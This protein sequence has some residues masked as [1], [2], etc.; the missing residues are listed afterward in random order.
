MDEIFHARLYR[1]R[2][3]PIQFPV[4]WLPG[5]SR[6]ETVRVGANYPP[7]FQ[8]RDSEGLDR[9]LLSSSVLAQAFYGGNPYFKKPGWRSLYSESVRDRRSGDRIPVGGEIFCTYPDRLRGTPS[10]L[11][12]GYRVF[13]GC[14]SGRSVVLTTHPSLSAKVYK[15][16]RA[17]P[18][19]SLRACAAYERVKPY[20][21]FTLTYFPAKLLS[22]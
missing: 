22:P 15:K 1:P 4:H 10:L 18:L 16:S 9:Y 2:S 6:G 5:L 13:P 7:P 17:I 8:H 21:T 11:Y 3:P 19:L 12:N 20:L 14:K